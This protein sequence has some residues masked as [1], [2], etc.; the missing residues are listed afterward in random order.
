MVKRLGLVWCLFELVMKPHI[1]QNL[2]LC[3]PHQVKRF[4]EPLGFDTFQEHKGDVFDAIRERIESMRKAFVVALE[5]ASNRDFS[6]IGR[7]KGMSN[8]KVDAIVALVDQ[9]L[10]ANRK[11]AAA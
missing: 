1:E 10:D 11:K 5:T 3:L 9:R 2:D 8:P 4:Q 7:Q 6:F